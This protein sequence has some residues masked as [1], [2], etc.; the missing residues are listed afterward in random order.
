MV[1][2]P[3]LGLP[4]KAIFKGP[5]VQKVTPDRRPAG[6]VTQLEWDKVGASEA[7]LARTCLM[8]SLPY[9]WFSEGRNTVDERNPAPL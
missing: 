7:D 6:Q 9:P 8:G 4:P 1:Q 2:V 3:E 5:F